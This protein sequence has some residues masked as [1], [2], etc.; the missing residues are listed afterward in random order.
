MNKRKPRGKRRG[1]PAARVTDKVIHPTPPSLTGIGSLNVFI[2]KRRAWRGVP[3][4]VTP[5]LM[6]TKL[7]TYATIQAAEANTLAMAPTPAG[8]AAQ[9]AE[10][11]TKASIAATMS[12]TIASVSGLADKHTCVLHGV[13]V[14]V[15]GSRTVLINGLPACRQG[16]T[17][18]EPLGPPNKILKG[19]SSVLIGD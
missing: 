15:G 10:K 1:K 3:T 19:C 12:S 2:G 16:D 13:G 11:S 5:A 4:A 9:A 6:S 8:P 18:V 17:I 14:V 7:S